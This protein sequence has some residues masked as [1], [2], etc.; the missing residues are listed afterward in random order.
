[1]QLFKPAERSSTRLRP[2]L[3]GRYSQNI[4]LLLLRPANLIRAGY[5][6]AR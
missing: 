5:A 3:R 4:L 2:T 6:M 1:M